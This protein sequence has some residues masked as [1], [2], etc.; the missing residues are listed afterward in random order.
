MSVGSAH[1]GACDSALFTDLY[2]LSMAA[3]FV[4]DGVDEPAEF[5]V[6]FRNLGPRR[7]YAL[8]AGLETVLAWLERFR[9]DTAELDYL[10]SLGQFGP[11]FL[12]WLA[13][14]RFSGDVDAMPEGTAV[15]PHE[16]ML[17]IRAPLPLA[18]LL[19][20]RVLN[21]LHYESLVLTKAARIVDAAGGRGVVDFGARRAHGTDA[22]LAAARAAWIAGCGGTSNMVAGQRFALP[23]VGTMAHSYIEAYPDELAAFRAFTAH[24]PETTLL[25]DTYDTPGGVRN[26]I[27]LARELG[28]AF[29][30]GAVR[31]D[32]G[33]LGDLAH[34][35]RALLDEAGLHG[36]R[37][38]ASGGLDEH[39]IAELVAADAPIDGFGVGTD[40]VVSSDVPTL[41]FAYKLV[42]YA[43]EP[44]LKGSTG[45]A[46]LPGAKQ[47]FRR[48]E[49]ERMVGDTIGGHDEALGVSP[50]WC[51]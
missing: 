6:F 32:S 36:V 13:R 39:R 5:E 40:L 18:Q 29:R 23:V 50:S 37:I 8:A 3:A 1:G 7:G 11:D 9:L 10:D 15:F 38:V 20:T 19:E 49:G 27:R 26:V 31:L 41:D 48:H 30:V 4:A 43:G 34:Q 46:T 12:D 21:A 16:P 45:K 2:E 44:R 17:R 25:V 51:P 35:A 14:A 28:S 24:Y 47:V 33:D 22:A 42:A